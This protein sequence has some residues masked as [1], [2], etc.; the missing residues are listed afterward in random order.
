MGIKCKTS[1]KDIDSIIEDEI[2]RVEQLTIRALSYLGE[3]CVSRVRDRSFAESWIDQTGNLRSSIG[4]IITHNGI[5]VKMSDFSQVKDGLDG[6]KEGRTLA[7]KLASEII[8]DYVL[9]VV[10]GMNYADLVEARDSKD[11]LASTELYAKNN[12]G[13]LMDKLRN[14][15]YGK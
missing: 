11:V 13:G 9:I 12:I 1:I 15:I 10:A 2:N 6:K 4:Y 5:V 8:G 14:Q 7:E 3:K